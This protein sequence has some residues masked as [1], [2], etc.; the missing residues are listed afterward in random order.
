MHKLGVKF[1]FVEQK[2]SCGETILEYSVYEI[3]TNHI[4]KEDGT[5]K[6]EK[7]KQL[8][9]YGYPE[10]YCHC[11]C[12]KAWGKHDEMLNGPLPIAVGGESE[13]EDEEWDWDS[14]DDDLNF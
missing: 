7:T 3:V 1:D 4:Q 13:D 5:T 14:E 11:H 8:V 10:L 12:G 6:K 9:H 2:C